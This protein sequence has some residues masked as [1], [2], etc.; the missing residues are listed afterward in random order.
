[1]NDE[2]CDE[3]ASKSAVDEAMNVETIQQQNEKI[4][5]A[6]QEAIKKADLDDQLSIPS[7]LSTPFSL[8]T[9]STI[10]SHS[11]DLR[12]PCAKSTTLYAVRDDVEMNVAQPDAELQND[13]EHSISRQTNDVLTSSL[14]TAL[15]GVDKNNFNEML[16]IDE[17]KQEQGFLESQDKLQTKTFSAP[18]TDQERKDSITSIS[19]SRQDN[20]STFSASDNEHCI[21]PSMLTTASVS[22]KHCTPEVTLEDNAMTSL[23]QKQSSD[24]ANNFNYSWSSQKLELIHDFIDEMRYT[25]DT[26]EVFIIVLWHNKYKKFK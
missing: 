17:T 20:T 16:N 10:F 6:S 11:N 7:G 8:R 4:A 18:Q 22:E 14:E 23:S 13:V 3:I 19:T 9:C 1:M 21:K 24:D 2:R 26:Y 5:H 12:Q 15:P 25:V